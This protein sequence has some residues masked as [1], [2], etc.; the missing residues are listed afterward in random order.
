MGRLEQLRVQ[1]I[2]NHRR[3]TSKCL[4]TIGRH[5][6]LVERNFVGFEH[7][8]QLMGIIFLRCHLVFVS[9]ITSR[10]HFHN[11]LSHRQ[12]SQHKM[13]IGIGGGSDNCTQNQHARVRKRML[14][15]TIHYASLNVGF[16]INFHFV[17]VPCVSGQRKNERSG[18]NKRRFT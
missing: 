4:T 9:P 13:A 7:H 5:N 18:E 2:H 14:C 10:A 11:H 8:I 15:F 12:I 3:L 1:N 17:L 16:G 6:N